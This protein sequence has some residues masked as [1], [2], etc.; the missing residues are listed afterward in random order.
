M[1]LKIQGIVHSR[2]RLETGKRRR[3]HYSILTCKVHDFSCDFDALPDGE[4]GYD[5]A[6]D[7]TTEQGPYH[8]AH[9]M[10]SFSDLKNIVAEKE[11]SA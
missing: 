7:K 4:V 8:C 3:V 10:D 6:E 2:T 1:A 5:P 11:N 9:V